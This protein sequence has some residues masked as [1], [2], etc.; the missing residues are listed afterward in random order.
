M[1]RIDKASRKAVI[2]LK[3]IAK[4]TRAGIEHA[5]YTTGQGL[6][7]ATSAEIL[8]KPKAGRTYI[9]RDRA[10]RRRRH[11][12]SAPGETHANM[13]GKLRRSLS[14]KVRP[15]QLEFGYGVDKNNAPE[16]AEDVEFGT[17]KMGERPSLSLGIKGQ[18]RN[19]QKNFEREIG[20]RLGDKVIQ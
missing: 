4:L 6:I 18:Y 15:D 20:K 10:G 14:F 16:Y 11:I 3:N 19:F 12:A 8:R 17:R 5:L 9:R 7:K 2:R 1:I 13:T